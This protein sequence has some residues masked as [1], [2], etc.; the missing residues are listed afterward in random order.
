MNSTIFKIPFLLFRQT[1]YINF[2]IFYSL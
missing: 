2:I 1:V